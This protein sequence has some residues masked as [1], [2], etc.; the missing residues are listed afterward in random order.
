MV[1]VHK[2]SFPYYV[3]HA[4]Q[5]YLPSSLRCSDQCSVLRTVHEPPHPALPSRT[6][7]PHGV[8]S[9]AD[10]QG[11]GPRW[12]VHSPPLS[13]DIIPVSPGTHGNR[14]AKWTVTPAWM[15]YKVLLPMYPTKQAS[16]GH[17]KRLQDPARHVRTP[18]PSSCL[19]LP[20]PLGSLDSAGK[21]GARL[22]R[23]M[24]I[25][26]FLLSWLYERFAPRYPVSQAHGTPPSRALYSSFIL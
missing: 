21:Q 24:L 23:N 15:E 1:G 10:Q 11:G 2:N 25:V 9:I 12:G 26:N 16:A 4:Y 17:L 5:R 3:S 19:E 18:A 22:T 7:T 8:A 20:R 6:P 14:T 13:D